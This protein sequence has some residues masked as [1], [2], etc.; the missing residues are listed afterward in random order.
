MTRRGAWTVA[1]GAL[2]AILTL[3]YLRD[4]GWLINQSSGFHDWE[5]DD[6]GTPFRWIGGHA[7]FF[8]SS[9]ATT[10]EIPLRALFRTG[11]T[12]PFVVRVTIND[13]QAAKIRLV[14]EN[15]S[16]ARIPIGRPVGANRRVVRIDLRVDHVWAD[17]ALGVEVGAVRIDR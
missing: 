15:W 3:E 9:A 8:V 4:P 12:R 10:I 13:R 16:H 17:G 6:Q 11:L 2:A 1:V 5:T 14:D 7:F